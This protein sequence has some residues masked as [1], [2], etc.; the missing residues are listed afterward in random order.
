M[1]RSKPSSVPSPHL[2]FFNKKSLA[3]LASRAGFASFKVHAQRREAFELSA[4]E[5]ACSIAA[6]FGVG[7]LLTFTAKVADT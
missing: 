6:L 4:A 1:G 7:G 5:V 3:E 2:Y